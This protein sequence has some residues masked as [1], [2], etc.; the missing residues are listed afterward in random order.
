MP[1]F[2][3]NWKMVLGTFSS[4]SGAGC[5]IQKNG[6]AA[7]LILTQKKARC[8]WL[9]SRNFVFEIKIQIIIWDS[10]WVREVVLFLF[11]SECFLV[12]K[13]QVG[14]IHDHSSQ[15]NKLF[16]FSYH[17]IPLMN[18]IWKV[19]NTISLL[20]QHLNIARSKLGRSGLRETGK[21]NLPILF[22]C[23]TILATSWGW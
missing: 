21:N 4:I 5:L 3:I 11:L 17:T 18:A 16:A 22:D 12:E 8:V 19:K 1:S 10:G 23:S 2:I 6:P 9:L 13:F 15:L 14:I 20:P 7:E